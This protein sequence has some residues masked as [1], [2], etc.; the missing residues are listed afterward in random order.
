MCYSAFAYSSSTKLVTPLGPKGAYRAGTPHLGGLDTPA[1]A[2]SV[3]NNLG[4]RVRLAGR[5]YGKLTVQWTYSGRRRFNMRRLRHGRNS[6]K[7]LVMS[8]SKT[9]YSDMC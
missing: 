6:Q 2:P 5:S 8:R 7:T 4:P 9:P 1:I 3:Q